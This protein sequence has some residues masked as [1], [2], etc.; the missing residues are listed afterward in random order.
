MKEERV[1]ENTEKMSKSINIYFRCN[2]WQSASLKLFK[3]NMSNFAD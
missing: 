1:A 2:V 3:I